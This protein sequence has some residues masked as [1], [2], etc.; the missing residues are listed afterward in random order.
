MSSSHAASPIPPSAWEADRE[1][2]SRGRVQMFNAGRPGG[3]DGWTIQVEQWELLR[4]HILDTIDALSDEDGS[5]PLQAVVET[6][7][8]L[9]A[10]HPLF[11]GGRLTNYVRFVKVDLEARGEVE[12]VPGSSPQRIRRPA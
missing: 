9:L 4:S 12:R 6:A 3:L 11:P 7:Q 8:V 10:T 5:V 2:R 1:A